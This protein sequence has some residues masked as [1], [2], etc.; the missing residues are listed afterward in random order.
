[1]EYNIE[2]ILEMYEDDYNPSSTVP[3]PRNMYAG[4][5]LVEPNADGSRPGYAGTKVEDNIRLRDNGN[6]YDVE[7]GRGTDK[8]GK[9][10]FFRKSF[11]LKN[12]KNK[13]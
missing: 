12:Y 13:N 11:N 10:N 9:K 5:Q 3:G 4:G 8:T 7:V 1:M 6:A 2:K